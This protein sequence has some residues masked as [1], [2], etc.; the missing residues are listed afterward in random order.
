MAYLRAGTCY[1]EGCQRLEARRFVNAW[2]CPEH[3]PHQ[4]T[5]DP[6]RTAAALRKAGGRVDRLGPYAIKGGSDILKE[7]PGG[8]VSRQRAQ[9]IAAGT[10]S[11]GRGTGTPSPQT[12]AD[13]YEQGKRCLDD[14]VVLL[15]T[16]EATDGKGTSPLNRRPECDDDLPTRMVRLF[17]TPRPQTK[18]GGSD[19][20][21]NW[22]ERAA[23]GGPNLITAIAMEMRLLPTPTSTPYGNNQSP[24]PGAAVR[25]SLDSLAPTLLPTPTA[26]DSKASGGNSPS[27]MTLTDAI[28]RTSLGGR[29]NPRLDG[30]NEPSDDQHPLPPNPT[31][32]AD[33]DSTPGSSNG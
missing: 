29:T 17:P 26:S 11:L 14:A 24:S 15:P 28:V 33:S 20:D 5:P 32:E 9:R 27:D 8:Y 4:P 22:H 31:A 21:R 6:A 2:R 25:P 30:G 10:S 16:P 19:P 18:G 12:A 13:R 1:T 7:R 3:A 23:A